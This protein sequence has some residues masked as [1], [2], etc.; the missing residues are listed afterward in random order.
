MTVLFTIIVIVFA[1]GTLT[2]V[3]FALF[4]MSPLPRRENPYRDP[5]THQ[6]RHE[7]PHLDDHT[8]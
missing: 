6:R 5:V 3:A 2:A 1:I 7:S 8:W 4:E